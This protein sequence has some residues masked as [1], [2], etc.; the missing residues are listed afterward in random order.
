MKLL[1]FSWQNQQLVGLLG[2]D[3][4]TVIPLQSIADKYL[5]QLKLPSTLLGIIQAGEECWQV[6]KQLQQQVD[7]I[8][9]QE[10]LL[11]LEDVEILA[12]RPKLAR[13]IFCV[14]KNYR[15]HVLE[16]DKNL[17]DKNPIPQ[18]PVI[19]TKATNTV[20]GTKTT[21]Q[22]HKEVTSRLDY[23]AELAIVIGKTGKNISKEQAWEHIFGYT[24]LNDVTARDL[25]KKHAQ[26][27]LGK[28]LDTF[29]PMGPVIT[30]KDEITDPHNLQVRCRINGELRQNGNTKDFIFDIPTI[31]ACISAGMTLEAGDIIATGTPD[32]VGIGFNPYKFLQSGDI[33]EVEIPG[34]G[35]LINVIGD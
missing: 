5:P 26:W 31:I 20:I 2:V 34:I 6:V 32:G 14:G 15:A 7:L 30:T 16:F 21:V 10:L 12:P 33:M 3:E 24:A 4:Q 8:A 11:A 27:F 22:A 29:A 1:T 28:S 25:Q 18:H 9:D 35:R 17:L 13:N 23:E 19:F